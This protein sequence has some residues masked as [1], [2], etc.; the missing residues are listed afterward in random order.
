MSVDPEADTGPVRPSN[1]H[2]SMAAVQ[3]DSFA[4]LLV[5]RTPDGAGVEYGVH[6]FGAHRK[7]LAEEVCGLLAAWDRLHRGGDGPQ[8]TAYPASTPDE[9]LE[10]DAVI[11][12]EHVRIALAWPKGA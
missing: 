7:G 4:Y 9:D 2:F 12:K 8:I 1:P 10:G 6:A 5:R 3:G 11:D